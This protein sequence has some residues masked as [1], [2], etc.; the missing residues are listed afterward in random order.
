MLVVR[1]QKV[2][3][4]FACLGCATCTTAGSMCEQITRVF[5]ETG[6]LVLQMPLEW[7]ADYDTIVGAVREWGSEMSHARR[8]ML[9]MSADFQSITTE[10]VDKC[11]LQF[12]LADLTS[13]HPVLDLDA[14][15]PDLARYMRDLVPALFNLAA[16][17][18]VLRPTV[19]DLT[20]EDE[21]IL[22]VRILKA[23]AS[24]SATPHAHTDS[25]C[26]TVLPLD[27]KYNVAPC[28]STAITVHRYDSIYS[29][30]SFDTERCGSN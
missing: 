25:G 14:V 30:Y 28:G 27:G 24:V 29:T 7:Q 6:C 23:L 5:Q 19:A 8:E 13:D 15:I 12:S 9:S 20:K 16:V 10:T 21:T 11:S 1:S 18:C 3:L 4:D 22:F 2:L 17:R 26:L